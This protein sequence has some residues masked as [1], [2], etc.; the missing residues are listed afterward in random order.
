[1]RSF[2]NGDEISA[3]IP[4]FRV[5]PNLVNGPQSWPSLQHHPKS[6]CYP[7]RRTGTAP[8]QFFAQKHIV[9]MDLCHNMDLHMMDGWEKIYYSY[10][11][12]KF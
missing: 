11:M 10:E 8:K 7:G 4:F 12:A 2:L 9:F 3:N 5:R 6:Q 1:M